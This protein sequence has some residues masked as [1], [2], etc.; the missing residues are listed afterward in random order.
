M[1]DA[2]EYIQLNGRRFLEGSTFKIYDDSGCYCKSGFYTSSRQTSNSQPVATHQ[3]LEIKRERG[4]RIIIPTFLRGPE[5][6]IKRVVISEEEQDLIF[7]IRSVKLREE[8]E[9]LLNKLTG[10]NDEN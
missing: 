6:E 5:P 1:M 4:K 3:E 8:F 9:E 7:R 2:Y 10:E